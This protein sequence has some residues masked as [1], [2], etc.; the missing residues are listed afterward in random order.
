MFPTLGVAKLGCLSESTQDTCSIPDLEDLRP[1][2]LR[3]DLETC[4]FGNPASGPVPFS[5]HGSWVLKC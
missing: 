5:Y 1:E 2:P 3:M 4:G